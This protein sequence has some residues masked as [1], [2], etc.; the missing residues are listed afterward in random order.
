[1]TSQIGHEEMFL[2]SVLF[3]DGLPLF[4]R[5]VFSSVGEHAADSPSGRSTKTHSKES[6]LETQVTG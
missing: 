2:R 4:S 1:M 6:H 3:R 5:K